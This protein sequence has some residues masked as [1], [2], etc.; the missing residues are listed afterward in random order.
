[1]DKEVKNIMCREVQLNEMRRD[2]EKLNKNIESISNKL[3]DERKKLIFDKYVVKIK[4]QFNNLRHGGVVFFSNDKL[5]DE[6]KQLLELAAHPYRHSYYYNKMTLEYVNG[7]L[8]LYIDYDELLEN[9]VK[10]N[11]VIEDID[12]MKVKGY[13][14]DNKD[15]ILYHYAQYRALR[16]YHMCNEK[17]D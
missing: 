16:L 3:Q 15:K 17:G 6:L 12:D 11:L 5:S 14:M 1:M 13:K 8:R 9:W 7:K 2:Y 4:W 10:Y